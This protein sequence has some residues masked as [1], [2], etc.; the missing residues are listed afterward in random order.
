MKENSPLS[1]I[2]I[3]IPPLLDSKKIFESKKETQ[4][5]FVYKYPLIRKFVGKG[6]E[7]VKNILFGCSLAFS[8]ILGSPNISADFIRTLRKF[9]KNSRNGGMPKHWNIGNLYEN[10]TNF[11]NILKEIE[12]KKREKPY[13][14]INMEKYVENFTLF[15]RYSMLGYMTE[16]N[17][18]DKELQNLF[19]FFKGYENPD[20]ARLF[21]EILAET[22]CIRIRWKLIKDGNVVTEE[23]L[24]INGYIIPSRIIVLE[25][26]KNEFCLIYTREYSKFL[27]GKHNKTSKLQIIENVQKNLGAKEYIRN[28]EI[29]TKCFTELA[30]NNQNNHEIIIKALQSFPKEKISDEVHSFINEFIKLQV[31]EEKKENSPKNKLPI[32]EN[33]NQFEKPKLPNKIFHYMADFDIPIPKENVPQEG[34]I[35][36]MSPP[37]KHENKKLLENQQKTCVVCRKK[38]DKQNYRFSD[39]YE[40]KC[41]CTNKC[42]LIICNFCYP[43][44]LSKARCI[45]FSK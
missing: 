40:Y 17:R 6:E 25:N 35:N 34:K 23:K 13:E 8:E 30:K 4:E 44:S 11:I 9:I 37:V 22:L 10:Q 36:L 26:E 1:P 39:N 18:N 5:I 12:N 3:D 15:L 32:E 2:K 29:M 24:P 41:T 45:F 28:I 14:F 7:Y 43:S 33:K 16:N 38:Y 31:K 42:K 27:K 19:L 21:K 20:V